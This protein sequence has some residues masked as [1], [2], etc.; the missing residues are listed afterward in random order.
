MSFRL[1]FYLVVLLI[2]AG[3]Y[4]AGVS[5]AGPGSLSAD[6]PATHQFAKRG[7]VDRFLSYFFNGRWYQGARAAA[8][9]KGLNLN[10][11]SVAN[12]AGLKAQ[13]SKLREAEKTLRDVTRLQKAAQRAQ[14]NLVVGNRALNAGKLEFSAID[15][16]LGKVKDT[17]AAL[18]NALKGKSIDDIRMAA[19]VERFHFQSFLKVDSELFA[20]RA[21]QKA[22]LDKHITKVRD[23]QTALLAARNGKSVAELE[24][25]AKNAAEDLRAAGPTAANR[26]ELVANAD[27]T[28]KLLDRTKDLQIIAKQEED[29]LRAFVKTDSARSARIKQLE[30]ELAVQGAGV[31]GARELGEAT[32]KSSVKPPVDDF[33][34]FVDIPLRR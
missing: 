5:A 11:L 26:R 15:K 32:T 9:R 4:H 29:S 27:R 24:T 17:E 18:L 19:Q 20:L 25:A 16:L 34:E 23:A 8:I 3:W 10:Y 28:K 30:A 1:T 33:D 21:A 12:K 14:A 6:T 2:A 13:L 22:D 7:T 31:Q